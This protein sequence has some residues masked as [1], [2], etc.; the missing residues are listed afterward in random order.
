MLSKKNILVT[1]GTGSFGAPSSAPCWNA[2]PTCAAW[3]CFSRDELKQFEMQQEFPRAGTPAALLHR[4][5][6]RPVAPAPR[7]EGIDIVVHAAALKQVPAAEYNPFEVHQDQ[8]ARR[9]ERDRGLPGHRRAARGGAVDR[10]GRRA[11]QPVRRDQAVQ[12]Q[13]VRGGQQHQGHAA[14]C[15][16]VV[17]YGNVMGSRGSVIPFFAQRRASGVLPITDPQMTRFN[18]SLQDGVDMVLWS[19]ENAWG[20]EILVPKIPSYRITDVAAAVAPGLPAD[21]GRHPPRREDPRGDDHR[22]RQPEHGGPGHYYAI[23]PSGRDDYSVASYD[24]CRSAPAP[25]RAWRRD[26]IPYDSGSNIADFLGLRAAAATD[27]IAS[28]R[29]PTRPC[30]A[31]RRSTSSTSNATPGTCRWPRWR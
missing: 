3:W 26:F 13:A 25:D 23:L 4:R 14:T 16:S 27:L 6:A 29:R 15:A 12:R 10:Q 22:Q 21:G 7:L 11:D 24:Y 30:T 1:G 8:R 2:T 20:G 19:I 31:V 18:I 28:W 5:R 17:R 9:A